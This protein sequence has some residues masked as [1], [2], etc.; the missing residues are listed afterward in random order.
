MLCVLRTA[1]L[2]CSGF[3]HFHCYSF[4][5]AVHYLKRLHRIAGMNDLSF[6]W[7]GRG[8]DLEAVKL[9]EECMKFVNLT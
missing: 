3:R 6:T 5:V 2:W 7:R 9:M 1:L 4:L 8:R